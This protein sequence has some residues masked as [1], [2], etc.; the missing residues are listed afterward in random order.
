METAGLPDASEASFIPIMA[1]IGGL[2]GS[3][4]ARLRGASRNGVRRW[5]ED[6][7]YAG[8]CVGLVIYLAVLGLGV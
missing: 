2:I 7:A 8:A 6:G 1:V 3:T 5:T 4:V